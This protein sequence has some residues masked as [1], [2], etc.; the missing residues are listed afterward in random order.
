MRKLVSELS[1][2]TCADQHAETQEMLST[3]NKAVPMPPLTLNQ[4]NCFGFA[5][6]DCAL[7][8]IPLNLQ[9]Q[10]AH[11]HHTAGDIK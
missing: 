8:L 5:A 10:Q 6:E 4:K 1:G 7:P 9:I 3:M 11:R 2:R